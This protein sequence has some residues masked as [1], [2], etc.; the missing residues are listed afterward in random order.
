MVNGCRCRWSPC[1]LILDENNAVLFRNVT[2]NLCKPSAAYAVVMVKNKS[3]LQVAD[4]AMQAR[5]IYFTAAA[6]STLIQARED[7]S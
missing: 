5:R 1:S 6:S 3:R 4:K 7:L 2:Y